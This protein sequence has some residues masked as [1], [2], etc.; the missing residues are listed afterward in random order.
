MLKMSLEQ[1]K[2]ETKQCVEKL[3]LEALEKV[4]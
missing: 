3:H 2:E 1:Q 4:L